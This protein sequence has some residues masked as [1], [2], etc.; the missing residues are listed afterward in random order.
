M[1]GGVAGGSVVC[2]SD[3][4]GPLIC[5]GAA[6]AADTAQSGAEMAQRAIDGMARIQETST[7]RR[8]LDRDRQHRRR[9]RRHR[10][11][12]EPAARAPAIGAARTGEQGCGFA[13]DNACA[14]GTWLRG[15]EPPAAANKTADS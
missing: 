12:D 8:V 2:A 1:R 13:F 14:F 7:A 5:T 15:G 3:G 9:D 6:A 11:A 10:G 4:L